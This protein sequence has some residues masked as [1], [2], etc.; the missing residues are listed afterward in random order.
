M[1]IKAVCPTCANIYQVGENLLGKKIRCKNCQGVFVLGEKPKVKIENE[2]PV[3]VEPEPDEPIKQTESEKNNEIARLRMAHKKKMQMQNINKPKSPAMIPAISYFLGVIFTCI[4]LVG[5][6]GTLWFIAKNQIKNQPADADGQLNTELDQ[7]ESTKNQ[8][9]NASDPELEKI[10]AE[11]DQKEPGWRIEELEAKRKVLTPEENSALVISESY[12]LLGNFEQRKPL[13]ELG[14]LPDIAAIKS[15]PQQ[16]LTPPS[17]NLIKTT[18]GAFQPSLD[19]A[20]K[21]AKLP[22]GR[23]EITYAPNIANTILTP[24]DTTRPVAE[25]L[26]MD[27]F[28]E[29]QDGKSQQAME[30]TQAIFNIARSIREIPFIISF[31]VQI[32]ICAQSI[33]MLERTI[34]LGEPSKDSLSQFQS[35]VE[36]EASFPMFL[37]IAKANRAVNYAILSALK[38]DKDIIKTLQKDLDLKAD[39]ATATKLVLE[40]P[41]I[42]SWLLKYSN[43]LVAIANLPIQDQKKIATELTLKLNE[44]PNLRKLLTGDPKNMWIYTNR[45]L[46]SLNCAIT[47]LAMERYRITNGKWPRKLEELVPEYL[48]KLPTDPF[49]GEPLLVGTILGGLVIYSVGPDLQDNNGLIDNSYSLSVKE[50]TDIGFRLWEVPMRRQ[51][52]K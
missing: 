38:K 5:G 45:N 27:A 42:L 3:D 18:L 31:G 21:V 6:G 33:R 17:I 1:S 25:L 34:A 15:S 36:N 43:S 9:A 32:E 4:V 49:N 39:E 16:L 19:E 26:A 7:T 37:Y 47:G 52:A 28:I 41:N 23:F 51:P 20:K 22:E 30:S 13:W 8:A 14:K 35:L 40:E 29:A 44:K 10:I 12:K 24:L 46:A 2:E 50:G 11:L 48:A